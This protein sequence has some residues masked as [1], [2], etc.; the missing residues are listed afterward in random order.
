MNEYTRHHFV[1]TLLKYLEQFLLRMLKETSRSS[2]ISSSVTNLRKC[3]GEAF[4]DSGKMERV[5]RNQIE[6]DAL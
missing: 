5:N 1:H 2:L 4:A 6:G 3:T